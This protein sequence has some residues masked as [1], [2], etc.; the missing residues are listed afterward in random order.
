MGR[1]RKGGKSPAGAVKPESGK[2][3]SKTDFVIILCILWIQW[4]QGIIV[5]R[6]QELSY[7]CQTAS[8]GAGWTTEENQ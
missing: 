6:Q 3:K 1:H 7:K 5:R 8:D 2:C 4:K